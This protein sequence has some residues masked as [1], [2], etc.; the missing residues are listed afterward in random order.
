MLMGISLITFNELKHHIC[1][2]V[3]L[4]FL[5]SNLYNRESLFLYIKTHLRAFVIIIIFDKYVHLLL[6]HMP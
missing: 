4:H 3:L 6:K 1:T 2:R 5:K